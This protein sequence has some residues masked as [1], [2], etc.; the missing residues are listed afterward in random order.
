MSDE[1]DKWFEEEKI[2]KQKTI[3]KKGGEGG[4]D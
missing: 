4:E 1:Q 2:N 3:I